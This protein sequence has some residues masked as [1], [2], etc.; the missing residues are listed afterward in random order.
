[1]VVCFFGAKV[2][3]MG[4]AEKYPHPREP[5]SCTPTAQIGGREM[6]SN[7]SNVSLTLSRCSFDAHFKDK[8]DIKRHLTPISA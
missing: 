6:I 4:E 1:M 7:G 8:A 5:L 3:E 2:S